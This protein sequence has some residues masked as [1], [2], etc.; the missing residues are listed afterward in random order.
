MPTITPIYLNFRSGFHVGIRGMNLE[1]ARISVPSDTL[2]AALIDAWRRSSG[3]VDRLTGHFYPNMQH[4]PPPFQLSSAFPFVGKVR[5][6]PMPADPS[7]MFIQK[8]LKERGKTLNRVQFISE[9]LLLMAVQGQCLDDYLY[10]LDEQNEPGKGAVLQG[11]AL[12]F[13]LDELPDLPVE[14]QRAAGKRHSLISIKIWSDQR[15]QRVTIDRIA[16]ASTIYQAGKLVFASSCGLWFG[17]VEQSTDE[18]FHQAFECALGLLADD[19]LGG[20]RTSGYGV[21]TWKKENPFNLPD[22]F[23]GQLTY[24]LSRYSP[25]SEDELPAVLTDARAAYRLV[26]IGGWAHSIDGPSQRRK[27][28]QM[29][30]EGSL[31][32]PS[33][34][35]VGQVVNVAPEYDNPAGAYPHPV[36][37]NGIALGIG[38]Q[39]LEGEHA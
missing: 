13:S 7:R 22:P 11:G 39:S 29:V 27:R 23:P 18:F 32:V 26:A 35:P 19:G 37:R 9:K 38:W 28:I 36:F 17:I 1:E 4:I 15:V 8:A 14:M 5:F 12:W 3:D 25:R 33:G 21:F 10:P 31:V 16:S 34:F 30:T 6:Y 24:I 2:F 20:E